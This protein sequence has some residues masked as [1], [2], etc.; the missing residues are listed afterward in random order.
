MKAG[1]LREKIVVEEAVTEVSPSGA[2]HK[3]WQTAFSTRCRRQRITAIVG[4]GMDAYEEFIQNTVILQVRDNKR[5]KDTQR[6]VYKGQRF[7]ITLINPQI[8][9]KTLYITLSKI[10]E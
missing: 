5:F 9:D 6:I 10:N 2:T 3:V 1:L 8:E 4:D 7:R